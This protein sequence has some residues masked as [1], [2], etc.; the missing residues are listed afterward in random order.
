[1][2]NQPLAALAKNWNES[3]ALELSSFV[4]QFQNIEVLVRSGDGAAAFPLTVHPPYMLQSVRLLDKPEAFALLKKRHR[5][6]LRRVKHTREQAPEQV[7]S[8]L[9]QKFYQP[10]GKERSIACG[11]AKKAEI[12][13]LLQAA[14]DQELVPWPKSKGYPSGRDLR[15][16]LKRYGIGIDCSGFVQQAFMQLIQGGGAS[17]CSTPLDEP[18]FKV[19]FLRCSWVYRE[20]TTSSELAERYFQAVPTPMRAKPGDL[21][22]TPSHMRIVINIQPLHAGGLIFQL[23]ESTSASDIPTYHTRV[24]T[25]IGPRFIELLYRAPDQPIGSQTPLVR[26]LS[27]PEFRQDHQE[28]SF[29]IGRF[30]KFN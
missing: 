10:D 30:I 7:K 8:F 28:S 23:A 15:R 27:E 1:M 20:L 6:R 14:V 11:R 5:D 4:D 2:T 26:R 19:P 12:S 16:W 21:L 24:E 17:L 9:E 22:V 3:V 29:L 18:A 13:L 25:D